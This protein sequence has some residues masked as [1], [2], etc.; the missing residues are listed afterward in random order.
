LSVILHFSDRLIRHLTLR[1]QRHQSAN[2][3]TDPAFHIEAALLAED[4][5]VGEHDGQRRN[6]H[7]RRQR[8]VVARRVVAHEFH[9]QMDRA[10]V[11][12]EVDQLLD[13]LGDFVVGQLAECPLFRN[14]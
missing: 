11:V 8:A 2:D 12:D 4:A 5:A 6:R 13:L 10:P 1:Q 9:R 7:H 14:W 3:E